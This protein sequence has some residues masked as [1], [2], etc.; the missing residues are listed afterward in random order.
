MTDT[1]TLEARLVEIDA[2]IHSLA[3]GQTAVEVSYDG[4]TVKYTAATLP[5]L[6]AYRAEILG[7]L[8]QPG[9]RVARRVRF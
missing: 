1:A 5:N 8:G 4:R 2:A 6:R 9:A 7:Q 3:L